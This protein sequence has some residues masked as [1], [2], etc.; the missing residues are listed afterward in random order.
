MTTLLSPPDSHFPIV[1]PHA[2]LLHTLFFVALL[3]YF[4]FYDSMVIDNS[5]LHGAQFFSFGLRCIFLWACGTFFVTMRP[6][7]GKYHSFHYD[8]LI[9]LLQA[10][11]SPTR[12]TLLVGSL[13]LTPSLPLS[14]NS[15]LTP[16]TLLTPISLVITSI[17]P[18]LYWYLFPPTSL[19]T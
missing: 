7:S 11:F 15:I 13:P 14:P 5:S 19:Q 1:G 18:V 3:L 16:N 8:T 2:H 9:S 6:S 10:F 17:F 12:C 4:F